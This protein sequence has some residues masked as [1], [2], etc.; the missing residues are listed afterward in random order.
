M[1]SI[2]Q[3]KLR[4]NNVSPSDYFLNRKSYF[5]AAPLKLVPFSPRTL[6]LP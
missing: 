4:T 2:Y 6:L 3:M 1:R 5:G